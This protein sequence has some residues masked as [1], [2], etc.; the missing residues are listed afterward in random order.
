MI[1]FALGFRAPGADSIARWQ[2]RP[3]TDEPRDGLRH[4]RHDATVRAADGDADAAF[5]AA[6]E[7]LV[8]YRIFPAS[9]LRPTVD[10]PDGVV[11]DGALVV[12][13]AALPFRLV[14]L[15]G[16]VRVLRTWDEEIASGRETGFEIATLAGH[17]ERGAERFVVRLE[18]ATGRLSLTIEAWSSPGSVLVRLAGPIGR[19]IQLRATRAALAAFLRE[20]A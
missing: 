12:F 19:W 8:R 15:E 11:R 5:E 17:P 10:T 16:A 3:R 1:R 9:V 4:D 6:R 7:R 13:R 20:L 2:Q 14:S 18:R